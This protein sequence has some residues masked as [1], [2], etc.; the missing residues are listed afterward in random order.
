MHTTY[1]QFCPVALGAEVLAERWTPLIV[2]E[3]LG[4]SHRFSDLQRGLP[5]V[6]R[7]LLAQRLGQLSRRGLV[8]RRAGPNGPRYELTEAGLALAPVIRALGEW[9]YRWA[10]S[11][12]R[13]EHLN[14]DLL[15]WFLRRRV[16]VDRLP[17]HRTVIRFEFRAPPPRR[18]FWLVLTR[19]EADLCIKD[20]GFVVDLVVVGGLEVLARVYLGHLTLA[21]AVRSGDV[22]LIGPAAAR[23]GMYRWLGISPFASTPQRRSAA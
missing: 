1:G 15:M 10:A 21:A 18:V 22:E 13:P 20:P 14:P 7:N 5:G 8:E 19:P 3:L 12:L 9:G 4:G 23:Q 2:R 17:E 11:D 16:R 6:S